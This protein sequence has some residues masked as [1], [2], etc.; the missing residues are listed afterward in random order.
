VLNTGVP[1][2]TPYTKDDI[3][4]LA[5]PASY[6]RGVGYVDNITKLAVNGSQVT[7]TVL[8]TDEYEV[9]LY[10]DDQLDGECDC[11][12]GAEGNF[13]K[14]CVAVALVHLYQV[15]HGTV[16]QQRTD[17]LADHL[18]S[19]DRGELIDLLLDAADRDPSLRQ[20]LELR[21]IGRNG[22]DLD[23]DD[24]VA[25]IDQ[26][27]AIGEFVEYAQASDY[28]DH[29]Y[30][31]ITWLTDLH[32]AG[33]GMTIV[34]L[35]Q[36]ALRLLARAYD[37]VDD[38]SGYVGA[39][40]EELARLHLRV[41]VDSRPNAKDL[42]DWL[43]DFQTGGFGW[44]SRDI[45]GY[46]EPLGQ[47]GLAHYGQQLAARWQAQPSNLAAIM[48]R[49]ARSQGDID[50][51]VKVLSTDRRYGIAYKQIVD[52]LVD[53]GRQAEALEWAERGVADPDR[54]SVDPSLVEFVAARY[55]ET[56]RTADVLLLLRETLGR[57]RSL[58]AYQAL[59]DA[60]QATGDWPGTRT[61]ALDL[62]RP[63]GDT[64]P[65]WTWNHNI[66]VEVLLWEGADAEAWDAAK[67]YGATNPQWLRLAEA[68]GTTHPH[69]A[70]PI[71]QRVIEQKV[72]ARNNQAYAEAADLV[73]QVKA[74]YTRLD[75][76]DARGQ[77]TAYLGKL[78][79]THRQKRNFMAELRA[80]GLP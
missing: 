80:R 25:G 51:V 56:G 13:C 18:A 70:I 59:H 49:W 67:K 54:P 11:P 2:T 69:D 58:A 12:F 23:L 24:A 20:R 52:V 47:D 75:A 76:P 7:A 79:T 28:A 65:R 19:L 29:V 1:P 37:S 50:L 26:F 6:D 62:L 64:T 44:P 60:A 68:R 72:E 41:C 73:A 55:I 22:A 77:A 43:L 10:L 66:L 34:N 27:L 63:A 35:V 31:L 8:G 38:S 30:D 17:D 5:G 14:H 48:E 61:W 46:G 21:T 78:C 4:D 42:A 53:A 36:Y 74:L 15:E 32:E 9:T 16:A 33:H 57:T 71:Y 40:P 3:L 45:T 39:A